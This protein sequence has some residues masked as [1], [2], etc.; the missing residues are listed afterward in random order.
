ML[1]P[2]GYNWV[3]VRDV[4][5][6]ALVSI[7]S[8]RRGEKYI[9]SGNFCTLIDLSKLISKISGKKTPQ[10]LAPVFLA[11]LFCPFYEF[12]YRLTKQKPMYTCQSLEL[13]IHAPRNI[14]FEKARKELDYSPVSL[15]ET[16]QDTFQ[17]YKQNKYIS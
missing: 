3:D 12:F 13:L 14:S 11:Q 17:W 7:N 10:L 4:V 5:N 2:G 6:A 16:L 8:G 15:E 9:L 1:I